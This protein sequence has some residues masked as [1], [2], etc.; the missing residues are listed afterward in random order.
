MNVGSATRRYLPVGVTARRKLRRFYSYEGRNSSM[1]PGEKGSD[2]DDDDRNV[3]GEK[4]KK[5]E[6]EASRPD[7]SVINPFRCETFESKGKFRWSPRAGATPHLLVHPG[8]CPVPEMF[9]NWSNWTLRR[10]VDTKEAAV[11]QI[12]SI[13]FRIEPD[14]SRTI[15]LPEWTIS[16]LT[17]WYFW[18]N[19]NQGNELHYWY[20]N[21]YCTTHT[22]TVCWC[23]LYRY[24]YFLIILI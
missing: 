18:L 6:K 11:R 23:L 22:K 4:E 16:E 14:A 21:T 24:I 7:T 19:K 3:K 20:S 2:D 5:K 17:L 13:L 15:C 9:E 1:C 10:F 8:H 12:R